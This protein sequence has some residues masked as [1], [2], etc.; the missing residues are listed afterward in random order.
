L[1][2]DRLGKHISKEFATRYYGAVGL[3]IDFTAR[4]VQEELKKKGLPWEKAKGF[5]G[6][7]VVSPDFIPIEEL[8]ANQIEFSMKKNGTLVQHGAS[9][10]MIFDFNAII[11]YVSQYMTLKIGDL[12]FTGTPSGVGKVNAGDELTGFIGERAMFQVKVK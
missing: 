4:D 3:G 8:N 11:A 10:D 1:R 5:D 9:S 6:S 7:A 2:I 12:I